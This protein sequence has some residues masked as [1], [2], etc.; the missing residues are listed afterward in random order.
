M[1][2][3]QAAGINASQMPDIDV[4]QIPDF[5]RN[6]LLRALCHAAETFFA[7][8]GVEEDYQAWHR[9][10]EKRPEEQC[11]CEKGEKENAPAATGTPSRTNSTTSDNSLSDKPPNVNDCLRLREICER[12]GETSKSLAAL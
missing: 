5:V 4:K 10:R 11:D 3:P 7:R 9:E 8:P 1:N 6:D 12:T 2:T